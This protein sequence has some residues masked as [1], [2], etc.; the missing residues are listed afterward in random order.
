MPMEFRYFRAPDSEMRRFLGGGVCSLCG[1]QGP[2]FALDNVISREFSE[3][4]RQGKIGCYDC[5]RRDRFGFM[6]GTDIG[7]ITEDGLL[8]FDEPDDGPKRIF[9]VTDDGETVTGNVPLI[10][11]PCPSVSEEAI[12][13]LRR[14]PSFSTWQDFSWPIHH[15]DFMA[16]LGIWEPEDFEQLSAS[17]NGRE[18][19]LEIVDPDLHDLWPTDQLTNFRDNFIVFECL[20]C[21]TKTALFDID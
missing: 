11:Q 17:G 19:F 3:E 14:T 20:H 7:V 13:E 16:Y 8:T 6:H 12:A 4:K 2:C 9:V 10:S 5:L 15:N 18:L 21:S 1:Q